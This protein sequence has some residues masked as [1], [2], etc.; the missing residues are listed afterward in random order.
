[1]KTMENHVTPSKAVI[2]IL[3]SVALTE[4]I[5]FKQK[6]LRHILCN[7]FPTTKIEF[8]TGRNR[9]RARI[10]IFKAKWFVILKKV[11]EHYYKVQRKIIIYKKPFPVMKL[12]ESCAFVMHTQWKNMK[13]TK[14][15]PELS[16]PVRWNLSN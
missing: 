16:R 12:I 8:P 13:F 11:G 9:N 14:Q 3:C 2:S 4:C 1:M 10:S 7:C 15:Q 5:F 6:I